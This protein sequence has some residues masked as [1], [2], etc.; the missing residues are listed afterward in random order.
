[1]S[2]LEFYLTRAAQCGNDAEETTLINVRERHLRARD[3]WLVMAERLEQTTT[4]RAVAAAEKAA[5]HHVLEG[6]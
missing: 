4:A 6:I 5:A 2:T 3:A 1:V